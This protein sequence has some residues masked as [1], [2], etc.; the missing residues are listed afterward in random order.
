MGPRPRV[1]VHQQRYGPN[2]RVR[3]PE[4]GHPRNRD[5]DRL[6]TQ[7]RKRKVFRFASIVTFIP[8]TTFP[9]GIIGRLLTLLAKAAPVKSTQT[10]VIVSAPDAPLRFANLIA[11]ARCAA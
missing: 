11:V 10:I 8:W 3:G 7:A 6:N 9:P 4:L 2:Q 1:A 5:A